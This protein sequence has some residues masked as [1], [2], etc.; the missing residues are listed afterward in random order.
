MTA[1]LLARSA[2]VNDRRQRLVD[3][4]VDLDGSHDLATAIRDRLLADTGSTGVE[5]KSLLHCAS[6]LALDHLAGRIAE[7]AYAA[8]S[9]EMHGLYSGHGECCDGECACTDLPRFDRQRCDQCERHPHEALEQ[10]V[11]DLLWLLRSVGL[12]RGVDEYLA[13]AA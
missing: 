1:P 8:R 11:D 4:A 10:R 9:I 12:G 2:P 3:A 13:G 7:V 5:L 6:L